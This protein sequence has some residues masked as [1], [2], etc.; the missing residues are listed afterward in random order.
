MPISHLRVATALASL[1]FVPVA[2]AH[3]TLQTK[4]API[5]SSYKAVLKVP[6]GCKGSPMIKLRVQVPEG[7]VNVKPQPKP[8]WTLDTVQ[9]DYAASYTVHGAQ[10]GSGVKEIVWAGG[11]LPDDRY[12]E[13]V[14]VGYLTDGLAP[15][16]TLYFP[17]VQECKEGV[18]RWIDKPAADE[19]AHGHGHG[20]DSGS[21][22]PGLKLLPKP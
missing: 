19:H 4:E 8:G 15:D 11:L 20:H 10:V 17:V 7:V 12:D 2:F 1:L 5:G 21:P 14:F 13:F 9:G 22:A 18:A 16:S 6:H 3:V